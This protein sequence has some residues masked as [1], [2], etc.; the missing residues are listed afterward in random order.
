MIL[1]SS[2]WQMYPNAIIDTE[3]TNR[4]F[5]RLASIYKAMG[6]SN[7]VFML[8]LHNPRLQ[9]I[10]PYSKN[11][12]IE[13]MA[14][15]GVECKQNFWY[16]VRELLRA[17]ATAGTESSVVEANRGNIALWWSFFN[18]ITFLLIQ[19]RQTGKSFS[20]DLLMTALMNFMCSNTQINLLT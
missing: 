9:G 10:D 3:T 17:P 20:T 16:A 19:P 15:I 8:A 2:D 18:H 4:S 7:N 12:T 14:M 13:Q 6:I 1:F 5:V 11:L